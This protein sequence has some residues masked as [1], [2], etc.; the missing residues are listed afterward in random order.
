MKKEKP[1]GFNTR[2]YMNSQELEVFFYRDL[3]LSHVEDHSHPYYELYYFL[4]G[5]VSFQVENNVYPLEKGDYLMV[6]PGDRHHPVFKSP[7]STY[8]RIVLWISQSFY[9]SMV[10][11]SPD[12]GYGFDHVKATG[13]YHFRPD[14]LTSLDIQGR[15]LGLLAE[16]RSRKI[17]HH[18]SAGIMAC[19]LL[20]LINRRIYDSLHQVSAAYGNVLYLNI[21]DYVNNHLEEDLSLERLASFFYVSKYHISHLFKENMGIS[22]HQYILKKRLQASKNGILSGLP[23]QQMIHQYGFSDYT[24]FYR[25][26]RKEFGL[27]PKEFREQNRPSL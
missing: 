3:D 1:T 21:C 20:L 2:Q 14:Y 24:S 26:F 12:F 7:N 18:T 6:P 5:N 8:Q 22:L 11:W 25:A 9:D 15:L 19:S 23:I 17:F 27:S 10:S 16:T 4:D 13:S